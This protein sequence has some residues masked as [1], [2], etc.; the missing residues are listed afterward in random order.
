MLEIDAFAAMIDVRE[1]ADPILL[2]SG[3]WHGMLSLTA[4]P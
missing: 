3:F 1:T 2:P 4:M